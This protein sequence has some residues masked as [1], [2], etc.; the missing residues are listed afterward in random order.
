MQEGG[1]ARIK[2]AG[3]NRR[4]CAARNPRR[5]KTGRPECS[6][7]VLHLDDPR[8]F[9]QIAD[10]ALGK[11]APLSSLKMAILLCDGVKTLFIWLKMETDMMTDVMINAIK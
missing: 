8:V 10:K 7:V 4:G 5:R 9:G 3:K 6:P 2:A 11:G 1:G